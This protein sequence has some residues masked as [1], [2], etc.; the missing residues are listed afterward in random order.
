MAKEVNREEYARQKHH[1]DKQTKF[2]LDLLK[3]RDPRS[4]DEYN[5]AIQK[6]LK[7]CNCQKDPDPKK[8]IAHKEGCPHNDFQSHQKQ[9][10]RLL[11]NYIYYK[12]EYNYNRD[13]SPEY[14]FARQIYLEKQAGQVKVQV[15]QKFLKGKNFNDDHLY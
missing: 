3:S 4:L 9:Q 8:G 5:D 7:D 2:A 13:Y 14:Y 15:K 12:T 10:R 1:K 11:K 6:G